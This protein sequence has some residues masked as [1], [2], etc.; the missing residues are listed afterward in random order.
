[1]RVSL[2]TGGALG[3][4]QWEDGALGKSEIAGSLGLKLSRRRH[5]FGCGRY[6]E[7]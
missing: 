5:I 6:L 7:R 2:P 1:M 4:L 3:Y